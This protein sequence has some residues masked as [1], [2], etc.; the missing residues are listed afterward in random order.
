M[1]ENFTLAG[2]FL[3]G[4]L[5][6]FSPCVLP[7]LPLYFS[8]LSGGAE[9]DEKGQL[10][11]KRE[12]T[13]INSFLFVLGIGAAFFILGLGAQ[14]IGQVF[15]R[16]KM[17]FSIVGGILIILL[18]LF[19]LGLF[20]KLTFLLRE[21]RIPL[22]FSKIRLS[23]LTAILMGFVFSFS[24]TPCVGPAL[25]S[26]LLMT[27]NAATEGSGMIY[28]FFYTIGFSLP[29]I[30]TGFFLS[31]ALNFFSKHKAIVKWTARIGG[32]LMILIGIYMIASGIKSNTGAEIKEEAAVEKNQKRELPTAPDFALYDQYGDYWKLED[33]KGKV[34]VLNFWATWCPPCRAE[35]PDFQQVY[36]ELQEDENSQVLIFGV[37]SPNTGNEKSSREIAD[38]L[39]KNAY[40]Y[41]S[42]MD[43]GGD[44]SNRY[45]IRAFPTTFVINGEGKI[46]AYQVG[47]INGQ[48]LRAL[49]E[50]AKN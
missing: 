9:K 30:I 45:Y 28:I 35:M 38:F 31:S 13:I 8:Y 7:L 21:K 3:Q 47:M 25:A 19:Q 37:A 14:A 42:L 32:I 1:I 29:F 12:K 17:I 27:S 11:Y 18:G 48:Q 24:W 39:Q 41:P 15:S 43:D 4:I 6:F 26:I 22:N 50:R 10:I 49:I 34:V 23:P 44:L 2:A 33:L 40:S 5:S 20:N 16:A 36:Q 46:A